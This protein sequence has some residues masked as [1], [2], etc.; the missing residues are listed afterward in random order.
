MV[1]KI[2]L[3]LTTNITFTTVVVSLLTIKYWFSPLRLR[4][5]I[6]TNKIRYWLISVF[7][8]AQHWAYLA[9]KQRQIWKFA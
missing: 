5:F 7:Y 4:H 6:S 1:A 3:R 9:K 2:R 8:R